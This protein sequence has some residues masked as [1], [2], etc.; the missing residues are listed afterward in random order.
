MK[1]LS[2]SHA[3]VAQISR[4]TPWNKVFSG[5]NIVRLLSVIVVL[6][7]WEMYARQLNPIFLAPPTEIAKAAYQMIFVSKELGSA[8]LQ[9]LYSMLIGL[10]LA[11][12]IGVVVG[13]AMGMS[14]VVAWSFDPY[15]TIFYAMPRIALLPVLILWLGIDL[16]LR[17]MIVFLGAFFPIVITTYHGIK[18]IDRDL[19]E[20]GQAFAATPWQIIRTI[21]L[22]ASVPFV[23]TGIR[24]GI[25]RAIVGVIVAEMFA[26]MTGLGGLIIHYGDYF[27]TA[28]MMVP[29]LTIAVV[30]LILTEGIK[31]V[32][33]KIRPG[34]NN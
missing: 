19:I 3:Q 27:R 5:A 17:I 2:T 10:G 6:T 22:P 25:G 34:G 28:E 13:F 21:I 20:T 11:T 32:E 15:I 9:S 31:M 1:A 24:L 12:G 26:A 16:P 18:N 8:F 33:R 29:I 30:S 23:V 7:V 4:S 14:R